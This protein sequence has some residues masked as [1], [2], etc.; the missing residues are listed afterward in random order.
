M[1]DFVAS[2][3]EFIVGGILFTLAMAFLVVTL[4]SPG[5]WPTLT[6][7]QMEFVSANTT[8]LGIIFIA[9]AY[10]AGVVGE[11]LARS[12]VEWLLDRQTVRHRSFQDPRPVLTKKATTDH[13]S[14]PSELALRWTAFKNRLTERALG[15]GYRVADLERARGERERQRAVVMTWHEQLHSEVQGQLKRLRLERVFT[16]S[17]AITAL[18]L[19]LRQDWMLFGVAGL[20]SLGGVWLVN[21]RFRRYCSSIALGHDL[22]TESK[23]TNPS[24]DAPITTAL[25]VTGSSP[26]ARP[27]VIFDLDGTLIDSEPS[28]A[29]GFS[30]GLCQVLDERG[31]GSHVLHPEDMARFRGGR[32][33]DTVGVLLAELGL[34][35]KLD[36]SDTRQ[37]VQAVIDWVSDDVAA[38]PMPISEAVEVAKAL[39]QRGVPLAVASS[40]A[41]PFIDAALEA[42]GL[43]D[44]IPI[45]VSA[46]DLP[47]G[48]PDPLVYLLTLHEMRL[49]ASKVVAIEDSKVGVESAIR[50][51]LKCVWFLPGMDPAECG[52][53]LRALKATSTGEGTLAPQV[54]AFV[55]PTPSLSAASIM[56]MLDLLAPVSD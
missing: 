35:S 38:N 32:V 47:R 28:W 55:S 40:S 6:H 41:L 50:A 49:P 51:G 30:I 4:A 9:A 21:T 16:L 42:L 3:V 19:A 56:E 15:G 5:E 27:G 48:K 14:A 39:H 22:V 46:I 20:A 1:S 11:S 13:H 44:A 24:G 45:R 10:A 18:A 17:L 25:T 29:R 26:D 33:P 53:E 8:L 31:H 43:R 23:L 54:E 34:D 12:Q 7:S 36:E 52:E 37:I 2:A